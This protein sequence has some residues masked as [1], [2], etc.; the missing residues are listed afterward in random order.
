M[1]AE[2]QMGRALLQSGPLG[3]VTCDVQPHLGRRGP[4]SRERIEQQ[5]HALAVRQGA[6]GEDHEGRRRRARARGRR[7]AARVDDVGD[8]VGARQAVIA[9]RRGE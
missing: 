7:E 5:V 1:L 3:A 6:K 2:P 8:D 4:P 9:N